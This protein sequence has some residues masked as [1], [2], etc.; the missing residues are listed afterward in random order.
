[1]LDRS[2]WAQAQWQGA[3][4]SSFALFHPFLPRF[5]HKDL[6]HQQDTK[7]T[8][9]LDNSM[10]KGLTNINKGVRLSTKQHSSAIRMLEEFY[11]SKEPHLQSLLQARPDEL[12]KQEFQRASSAVSSEL[13]PDAYVFSLTMFTKNVI[14]RVLGL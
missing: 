10:A 12:D 4:F 5:D 7:T 3:Y 2:L 6:Q 13:R 9:M 1:V 11:F 14:S 8:Q